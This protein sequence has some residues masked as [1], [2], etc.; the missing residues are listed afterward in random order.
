MKPDT[1]GSWA[2]IFDFGSESD[3]PYPNLFLTLDSGNDN[4]RLAFEAGGSSADKSLLDAGN[5]LQTGQWQHMAVVIDGSKAT[6]Y[7]NGEEI[8]QDSDFRFVPMLIT[9]MTSNML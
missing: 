5:V 1:L 3:P 6:L 2:R 4:L 7:L 8:A 9:N